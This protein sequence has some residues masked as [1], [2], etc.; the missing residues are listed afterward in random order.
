[1]KDL[2]DI[3]IYLDNTSGYNLISST[4][5]IINANLIERK[6]NLSNIR[7]LCNFSVCKS[8][9]FWFQY[10][11]VNQCVCKPQYKCYS[12]LHNIIKF[13]ITNIHI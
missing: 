9:L 8:L 7:S 4:E 2:C 1:M 11:S 10:L 6:A 13:N 3:P 12:V 5:E